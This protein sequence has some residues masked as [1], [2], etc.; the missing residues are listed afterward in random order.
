MI[1]TRYFVVL[2]L[3]SQRQI[4]GRSKPLPYVIAHIYIFVGADII[5]PLSYYT[6]KAAKP[7]FAAFFIYAFFFAIAAFAFSAMVFASRPYISRSDAG[8]PLLP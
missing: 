6:K 4:F 7:G 8:L 1:L 2:R 5:R 3:N